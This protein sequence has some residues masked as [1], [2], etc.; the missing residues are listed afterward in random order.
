[1]SITV[2]AMLV[3]GPAF[4]QNQQKG[5]DLYKKCVECHGLRGEGIREKKT[6][7]TAGQHDW[8]LTASLQAFKK[9]DRKHPSSSLAGLSKRDIEDIALWLSRL[10]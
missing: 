7:K 1:M 3:G 4:S 8:Y 2:F 9:G 6:P 5:A 10:E